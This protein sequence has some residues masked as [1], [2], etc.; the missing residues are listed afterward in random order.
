MHLPELP[1]A[2]NLCL[3]L[4]KGQEHGRDFI[5]PLATDRQ[6]LHHKEL[7]ILLLCP[8]IFCVSS[9][10]KPKDKSET[11]LVSAAYNNSKPLC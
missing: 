3:L 9:Q 8:Q 2:D 1:V 4:T 11:P 10:W 5:S 6:D 7:S